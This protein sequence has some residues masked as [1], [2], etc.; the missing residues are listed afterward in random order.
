MAKKPENIRQEQGRFKKGASGNPSGK[1][2]GTPTRMTA[3]LKAAIEQSFNEVGGVKYLVKI[4]KSD[5]STYLGIVGKIIPKEISIDLNAKFMD[6]STEE[7][8]F[9]A[10][11]MMA[12]IEA[13]KS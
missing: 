9:A 8:L 10:K 5:P 7:K 6:M 4:A 1:P 12:E 3:T 11:K 2:K 13:M